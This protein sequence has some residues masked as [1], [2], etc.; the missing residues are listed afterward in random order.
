MTDL[1]LYMLLL[2]KIVINR[3]GKR[4]KSKRCISLLI[5]CVCLLITL[6]SCGT[7]N[8]L[9][10]EQIKYLRT[11]SAASYFNDDSLTIKYD[12]KNNVLSIDSYNGDIEKKDIVGRE[13]ILTNAAEKI[14]KD[15]GKLLLNEGIT[16]TKII[17]T[18]TAKDGV[19]AESTYVYGKQI[20]TKEYS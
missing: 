5:L 16:S 13:Y 15:T 12:E 18:F 10:D 8:D 7:K 17:V 1:M 9:T 20:E 3:E 11:F 4:M 19:V 6:T 14:V 2:L